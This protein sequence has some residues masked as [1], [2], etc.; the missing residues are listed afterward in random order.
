MHLHQF[1]SSPE[2][3]ICKGRKQQVSLTSLQKRFWLIAPLFGENSAAALISQM[4]QLPGNLSSPFHPRF[5]PRVY[6]WAVRKRREKP[7]TV[8]CARTFPLTKT[9][10]SWSVTEYIFGFSSNLIWFEFQMWR[11]RRN[12]SFTLVFIETPGFCKLD[13]LRSNPVAWYGLEKPVRNNKERIC[14]LYV[15]S[16]V[17]FSFY[18]WHVY[19]TLQFVG[20]EPTSSYH[21]RSTILKQKIQCGQ[22]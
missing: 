11:S 14:A 15:R 18:L 13:P 10:T 6:F 9:Q 20:S 1:H 16:R 4:I 19:L 5:H 7:A 2:N 8:W 12:I 3:L 21:S 17:S 22:Y